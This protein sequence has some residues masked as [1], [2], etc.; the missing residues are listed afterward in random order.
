MDDII[1]DRFR[2]TA[3]N[4]EIFGK[5]QTFDKAVYKEGTDDQSETGI[6]SCFYVEDKETRN[7]DRNVGANQCTSDVNTCKFLQD[8][9]LKRIA[10]PSAGSAIANITSSIG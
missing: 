1:T 8:P 7:G 6:K 5:V 9:I 3:D 2:V 4:V 10:E